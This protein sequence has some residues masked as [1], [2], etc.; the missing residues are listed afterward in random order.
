MLAMPSLKLP[1]MC[2]AIDTGPSLAWANALAV[3]VGMPSVPAPINPPVHASSDRRATVV[4]SSGASTG[5]TLAGTR[6]PPRCSVTVDRSTARENVDRLSS[7]PDR[8]T[9]TLGDRAR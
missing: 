6:W 3:P 5:G 7:S 4:D 8:D 2:M 9:T 1:W